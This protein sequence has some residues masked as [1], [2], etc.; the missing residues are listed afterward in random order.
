MIEIES[1]PFAWA[2]GP[3]SALVKEDGKELNAFDDL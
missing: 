2:L 1:V 3:V